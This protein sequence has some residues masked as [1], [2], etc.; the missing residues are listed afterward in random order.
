MN[1][2]RLYNGDCLEVMAGLEEHSVDCVIC[3]LPY[4]ITSNKWDVV[5]P[6]DKL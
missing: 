4:G 5:I 2:I 1:D 3:D 6:F